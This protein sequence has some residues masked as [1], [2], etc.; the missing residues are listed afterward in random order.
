MPLFSD[1]NAACQL[2]I[3]NFILKQAEVPFTPTLPSLV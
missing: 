2:K 3:V 1:K